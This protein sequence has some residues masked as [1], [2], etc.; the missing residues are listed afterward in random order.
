MRQKFFL[1]LSGAAAGAVSGFWGGCGGMLLVPMLQRLGW[2]EGVV[3]PS[4]M[5]VMLPVCA[6]SLAFSGPIPWGAALPYLLGSVLGGGIAFRIGKR[7]PGRWLHLGLGV[8]LLWGGVRM[9]WT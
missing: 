3:F 5:A 8:L 2:P 9:L 1:A 7:I 6:V 4:A